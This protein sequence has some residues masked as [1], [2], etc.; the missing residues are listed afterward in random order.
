VFILGVRSEPEALKRIVGASLEDIGSKLATECREGERRI[1][2]ND[3]LK[4]NASELDR[5]QQIVC[6]FLF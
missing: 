1:W 2:A 3:L 6:G 4:I 5:L